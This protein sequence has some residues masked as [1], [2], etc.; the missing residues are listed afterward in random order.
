MEDQD[1]GSIPK[2]PITIKSG[3]LFYVPF[4]YKDSS[5]NVIPLTGYNARMQIW[6]SPTASGTAVMD[7][8]TYGTNASQGSITIDAVSFQVAIIILSSFTSV[9]ASSLSRGWTEFHLFDPS[10]NDIPLF[11]GPVHFESGGIR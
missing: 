8:G 2:V 9:L 11:E 10:N 6:G 4:A 5:G 7:I 1:I 3:G